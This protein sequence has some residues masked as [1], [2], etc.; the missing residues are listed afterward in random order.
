MTWAWEIWNNKRKIIHR[1]SKGQFVK[2]NFHMPEEWINF[3][4]KV[5]KETRKKISASLKGISLTEKRKK[6]ISIGTIKGMKDFSKT[7][8]HGIKPKYEC[9]ICYKFGREYYRKLRGVNIE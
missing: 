3:G 2:G 8:K 9:K 4:H 7:C 5:S 1:N 6:N